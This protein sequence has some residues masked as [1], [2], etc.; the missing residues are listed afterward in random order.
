M[1]EERRA[2]IARLQAG[3]VRVEDPEST[4]VGP[5]VVVEKGAR[6]RPFTILEG[7]TLVR[8]GAEVG[9]FVRLVDMEV[10]ASAVVLDHCL[11]RESVVE[12]GAS[13]GPFAHLRPGSRV[14]AA[15]KV[16]NFVE[17]KKT[18]LGDG[19]KA[20]H[21]SY[22]GD[23]T[24]G[25]G[26]NVGAGTITCNYDGV[27]KSPTRIEKGAFVGSDSIL[28][29]PVTI[30]EGAYVA[31]GSTI[32]EDVP[33]D[34]LALGPG[35]AGDEARLGR[36]AAR[37]ARRA[38]RRPR[39]GTRPPPAAGSARRAG[40]IREGESLAMCGIVGYVGGRDAVP[41]ILDGLRRL[42]Y[43]GY[44]S[45]GVAVVSGGVLQRR[46]SAGKLQ[47]L[48]NSLAQEPLS[49]EWGLGPHALGYPRP[50]DRGERPPAPGLQRPHRGRAQRHHREPPRAQGAARRR[51]PPLRHRRPTPRSSRTW[52]SRST[53]ARWSRPRARRWRRCRA[54]TRWC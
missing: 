30:G 4:H 45:A 37:E 19:S 10:G 2:R 5:E 6:L 13:V 11:L 42:E 17:L 14:G 33:K 9:P 21:L 27:S 20:Q 43:R 26:V 3:G 48:A 7:R 28:V 40:G 31:A 50:A 53:R 18:H 54:S 39:V 8:S 38:R 44:D 32:T 16:G 41:V 35:A 1:D 25:P 24:I 22:L 12:A 15:A 46:R 52:S 23:A 47:N 51:G 29:A 36:G 34:A 49:G